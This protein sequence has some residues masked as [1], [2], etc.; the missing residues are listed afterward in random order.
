MSAKG[1]RSWQVEAQASVLTAVVASTMTRV[2]AVACPLPHI[3][4]GTSTGVEGV[5][6]ITVKAEILMH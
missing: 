4:V 1:L 6:R 2:V 3:A 5:A